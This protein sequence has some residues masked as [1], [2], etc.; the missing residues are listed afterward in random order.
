M[1]KLF[2]RF[3]RFVEQF[4]YELLVPKVPVRVRSRRTR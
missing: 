1:R 3:V 2:E 4:G